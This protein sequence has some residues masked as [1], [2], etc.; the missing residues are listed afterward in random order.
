MQSSRH[1]TR[2]AP[3]GSNGAGHDGVAIDWQQD[4]PDAW[5]G[6]AVAP[7]SFEVFVEYEMAADRTIGRDAQ[8]APCYC[9]L[10]YVLTE[11]R[12]DDDDLF[13][14]APS[15]AESLLGWRLADGRWLVLRN[16]VAD[17]DRGTVR[18]FL[19]FS[20]SMPR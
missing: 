3:C 9:A 6:Q 2:H 15:Y 4:L 20:A 19:T 8:G 16:I 5:L 7:A 10:R 17:F 1:G 13:Y 18:S 11:L 14:E 12:A